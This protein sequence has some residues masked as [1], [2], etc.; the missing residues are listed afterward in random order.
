MNYN[1]DFVILPDTV[2]NKMAKEYYQ[3]LNVKLDAQTL[4]GNVRTLFELLNNCFY[5]LKKM[6]KTEYSFTLQEQLTNLEK[7]IELNIEN[8]TICY[9]S[10]NLNPLTAYKSNNVFVCFSDLLECCN[11]LFDIIEAENKSYNKNILI[12]MQKNIIKNLKLTVLN[13]S[14]SNVRIFKYF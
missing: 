12:K 11:L 10:L 7:S 8:L 3:K 9:E 13:L 6:N 4:H 5:S 2:I 1:D 14:K